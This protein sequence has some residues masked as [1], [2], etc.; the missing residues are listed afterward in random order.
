MLRRVLAVSVLLS[1]STSPIFAQRPQNP[2]PPQQQDETVRVSTS[3]VQT[4]VIV[5]EIASNEAQ[6][7][8]CVMSSTICQ[9][10]Q[11]D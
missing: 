7:W 5:T 8:T 11:P 2:T 10:R 3:V 9:R 4:D 1:L 6:N